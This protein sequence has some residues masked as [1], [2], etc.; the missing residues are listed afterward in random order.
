MSAKDTIKIER[1]LFLLI[2][3]ESSNHAAVWALSLA[4]RHKAAVI[5]L[6]VLDTS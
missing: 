1:I 5:V 2:F 6:H 3:P 4:R